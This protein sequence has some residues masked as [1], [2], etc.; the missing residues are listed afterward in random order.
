MS[1]VRFVKTLLTPY[2]LLQGHNALPPKVSAD[3]GAAKRGAESGAF[4][5]ALIPIF[6]SI[7]AVKFYE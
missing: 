5:E 1:T 4:T 7:A 3:K 2:A 6:A